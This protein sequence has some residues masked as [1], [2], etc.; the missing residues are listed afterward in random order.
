M[1]AQNPTPTTMK[2]RNIKVAGEMPE[3]CSTP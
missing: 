1:A 3:E 2:Q